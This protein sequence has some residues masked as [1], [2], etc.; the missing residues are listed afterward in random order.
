MGGGPHTERERGSKKMRPRLR[1]AALGMAAAIT[2]GTLGVLVPSASAA[3]GA[4]GDV[5]SA[6]TNVTFTLNAGTLSISA[7]ASKDLGTPTLNVNQSNLFSASLG[8][9]TVTDNRSSIA[10]WTV[11]CSTGGFTTG[12]GTDPGTSVAAGNVTY[13]PPATVAAGATVTGTGVYAG[14]AGACTG[15]PTGA[16]LTAEVGNTVVTWNPTLAVLVPSGNVAGLYSG[17]ITQSL[18]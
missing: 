13:T 3:C 7:P 6:A 15:A 16:A 8:N 10:G 5:C 9:T 12:N 14:I 1:I 11:A 17:T 4:T 2:A 18:T